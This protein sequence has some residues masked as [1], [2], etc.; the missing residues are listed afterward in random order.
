MAFDYKKFCEL[1]SQ[2]VYEA[3]AALIQA[4]A[5]TAC[6]TGS[7]KIWKYISGLVVKGV[8]SYVYAVYKP[9]AYQRRSR[10]GGLGDPM[11]VVI[12]VGQYEI[13][14]NGGGWLPF[15]I[16]N[17][18]PPGLGGDGYIA[19]DVIAGTGYKFA[20]FDRGHKYAVPR[21][22]YATYDEQYDYYKS[23]NI[24]VKAISGKLQDIVN[25]AYN[26]ALSALS[27]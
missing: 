25:N 3:L 6:E 1:Y 4:E 2:Y 11:N 7:G 8:R 10:N 22:F 26:M 15:E 12:N 23:G 18:T 5:E 9:R 21:D 24:I 17:T 16:T 19:D 20:H 27:K 14:D 13:L